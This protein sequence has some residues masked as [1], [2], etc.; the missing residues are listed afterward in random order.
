MTYQ[1]W[2]HVYGV[3]HA[4]CPRDCE[5]PQPFVWAT[6][7]WCGRCYFV[8]HLLTQCVPCDGRNFCQDDG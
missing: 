2:L 4:H 5:H 7:L 6:I 8:K 3:S 1:E